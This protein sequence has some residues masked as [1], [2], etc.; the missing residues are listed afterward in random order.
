MS[1]LPF[2]YCLLY[3][4]SFSFWTQCC[5]VSVAFALLVKPGQ[6]SPLTSAAAATDRPDRVSK[7][8]RLFSFSSYPSASNGMYYFSILILFVA[9]TY[10]LKSAAASRLR[11]LA[12][13][14]GGLSSK[15][16]A[17]TVYS[18]YFCS[19]V[20]CCPCCGVVVSINM[21]SNLAPV[22]RYQIEWQC[23]I[24]LVRLPL[25]LSCSCSCSITLCCLPLLLP[26]VDTLVLVQ[27]TQYWVSSRDIYFILF[28]ERMRFLW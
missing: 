8:A 10:S 26:Y 23:Y 22:R 7:K 25:L 11:V 27:R 28:S 20:L 2:R 24:P 12:S 16:C 3:C 21:Y 17:C 13:S 14:R 6:L 1:T 9:I 15:Q 19:A 4:I 18:F 5:F